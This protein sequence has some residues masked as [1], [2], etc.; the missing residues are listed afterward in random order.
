MKQPFI[1]LWRKAGLRNKYLPLLFAAV[2]LLSSFF[3]Q[4]Q[5]YSNVNGRFNYTDSIK[6][7]K[8]KNN[9]AKD[10]ILST[11]S[12]GRIIFKYISPLSSNAEANG[13]YYTNSTSQTITLLNTPITNTLKLL[14]N[15]VRLP[16]FKYSLS[17]GAITLTD[18]RVTSDIFQADYKF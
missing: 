5:S 15:G 4:A 3:V 18:T 16:P 7:S 17:G 9:A 11:D 6:F 8:L 10:S 13:E 12:T 2:L 14:K 1:G